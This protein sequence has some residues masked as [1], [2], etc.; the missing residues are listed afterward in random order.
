MAKGDI[1]EI[2]RAFKENLGDQC[3]SFENSIENL[4]A[5]ERITLSEADQIRRTALG[6]K[7]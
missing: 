3:V 7:Q 6:S 2:K 1:T 4:I 5:A